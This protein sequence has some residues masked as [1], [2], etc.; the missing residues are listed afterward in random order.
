M[1]SAVDAE[2][3][4]GIGIVGALGESRA[5]RRQIAALEYCTGAWFL[6]T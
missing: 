6:S 4:S 3:A 1:P 5:G 2:M